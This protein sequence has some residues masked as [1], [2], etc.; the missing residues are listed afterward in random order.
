MQESLQ[1][2]EFQ[3][4]EAELRSAL[5][6]ETRF[7]PGM[8]AAY[9]ADASNYRQVPIGVVLPR[10]V[11]DVVETMRVCAAHGVPVLPRGGATS[12][13]GQ[14]VNVAVVVDCSKYLD[15]VLAIDPE[16]R[17][18][19]VEPGAVCDTLRD[20]AEL[21]GLTFAPDPATHSRCTLGG[22]IGNNS[23]GPHSVMAGTT[24]DNV[25]RLEVLT[26][27]GARF[28]CGATSPEE[29]QRIAAAGGRQAELYKKLKAIA[30]QY[31]DAIRAGFPKIKRRVSGYNLDQLLPE[32]GFHVARAL[33]GSEGTCAFTLQAETRLVKSPQCRV[34][35]VLGFPD[36]G[37]AGD[38]VPRVLATGPIACEGLDEA[39]IGG[40][41]ERKLRLDDIT[42]LPPGKAWLM[43]EY[44]ADTHEEA[45]ARA[46]ALG[47]NV[48]TDKALMTR[49][50]TI[51]E[52][53]ASATSLNLGGKGVD[54]VVGWEDA[55]V[56]PMRLG[57]YLREFEALVHRYGYRTSL[58]G[59]FGDGCIHARIN[60]ELRT[61][62]GLAHWRRF[63]TEAAHL[64]VKYGGSLSG[65]H[66]DGQA[67]GELLPIMFSPEL[68]QAF[69]EF[70]RA[71]DPHNRMNPGKLIDAAPFDAN[72]R[73]G[74]DYKPV[75][76]KTRMA[77]LSP[78][79]DGFTRAAEHCIGMG[80]CRSR[81]GG[82][83]CPSYRATRE[84]RYSTRGRARLLAEMLRGEVITQGWASEE[85]REAL[86]WCLG[87]KGCRSDCPTHTDM[88]AY[89]A[90]FMSH[91][92]ETHRRPRQSWSMG[93]IGEWAPVGSLFAG[94]VNTFGRSAL[95][96]RLA[97]VAPDRRLPQFAPRTFRA[98]FKPAG[99]GDPVVLFDDTLN[100]HFRPRTAAAAQKLLAAA[101]CAVELPASRVCCGRPYYDFGMLDSAKR[102]LQR[103][104]EVLA[105]RLDAGV[106]IVVLE[107]SCLSVFRDELGQLLPRDARAARLAA[108]ATSLSEFLNRRA[109]KPQASG[110]AL[111]HAH[112]HQKALWGTKDDAALLR[113]AGME[114]QTP[115][116]GC[117]G[118][119]GSFGYRPQHADASRRIAEL[120]LLPALDSASD[121]LVVASGFSC[122]E[123]IESLTR[124]RTLHIAEALAR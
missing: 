106:P 60:F 22:M 45:L 37:A 36:I 76:L 111:L 117:C 14:C 48:I 1:M 69:R 88:A 71:W 114:V 29:F 50:W 110:R 102:A 56:D 27:D 42:L 120:A 28:W 80:K 112:C 68:M 86:D 2:V 96:K 92:Y 89:K 55:A 94:F 49:L 116:V 58:Y 33:V 100:N 75:T 121:A 59:H 65:E 82:T 5:S 66:G 115:D 79:G 113:A 16:A 101:G 122:R 32:K 35:V 6:G 57:G 52:T 54:P 3:R 26:Y 70:K 9:A 87:C 41:R 4:L 13:N 73:L 109:F 99:A 38:A 53:G 108:Q 97:G 34:L 91:Y 46:S 105:P 8:R 74:P 31:G 103:V 24:V 124:R 11:S 77:F 119:A 104:L 93:R 84:E 20:A 98:Q 12:L 21:H 39:I 95:A 19:R 61:A 64:V 44:G 30:D 78:V 47:G 18:A 40:L 25:E 83:M 23:C 67:K 43:V 15:R 10:G 118:M 123:Q 51:R 72:L 107:P 90:E 7:D 85:V 63:L 81:A 62:S 17:L